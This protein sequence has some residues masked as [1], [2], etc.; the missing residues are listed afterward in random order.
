[1]KF[2]LRSIGRGIA[3][4]F[5]VVQSI[6]KEIRKARMGDNSGTTSIEVPQEP[7]VTEPKKTNDMVSI[8]VEIA[9]VGIIAA[10]VLGK[11]NYD[12][13]LSLVGLVKD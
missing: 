9:T 13:V 6:A 7:G 3:N 10:F 12:Q 1:M 4:G 5:P 8:I 2:I 11:I